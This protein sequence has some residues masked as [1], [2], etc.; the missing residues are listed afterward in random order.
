MNP[1]HQ[2]RRYDRHRAGNATTSLVVL[3]LVLVVTGGWNYHRN[4]QA[5]KATESSRPYRSYAVADLASLRDA[6]A[7]ELAGI[8]AKFD[9][10]RRRRARPAGDVGSI[11]GNVEQF[12]KATRASSAIRRAAADVVQQESQIAALDR[13][14]EI[15]SRFGQGFARHMKRLT[16]I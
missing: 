10:A 5:E 16:T 14:L 2:N 6:Y 3:L 13:E 8:K 7:S 11:A 12:Q 15:R 1:R 4:W 9:S